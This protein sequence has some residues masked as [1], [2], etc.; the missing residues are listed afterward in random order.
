MYRMKT[1][2]I[3]IVKMLQLRKNKA[4]NKYLQ[5]GTRQNK[6]E[7]E[8]KRK[9]ATKICRSKKKEMIGNK[10]NETEKHNVKKNVRKF[11][12]D[13]EQFNKAEFKPYINSCK[14]RRNI[15]KKFSQ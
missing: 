7:Y 1:G 10:L 14:D 3:K 8:T 9:L 12:K 5:R 15:F 11:Y 2:L 13:M 4:R 6:E